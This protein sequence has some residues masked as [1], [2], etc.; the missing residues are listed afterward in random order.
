MT[1]CPECGHHNRPGELLCEACGIDLIA[2]SMERTPTS[3]LQTD[4]LRRSKS[5]YYAP[6]IFEVR[7]QSEAIVLER[8]GNVVLGRY[9]ASQP[10]VV[11]DY[12]LTP[13]GADDAGVS[14]RH[15]LIA[16]DRQPPVIVDLGSSNGTFINGQRL[17]PDQPHILHDGDEVRLG[18]LVMRVNF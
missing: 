17:V 12:D 9:D 5:Q 11:P 6:V 8:L 4:R 16:T 18:R 15:A 3:K 2:L 14:R 13:F 7:G 1:E 10:D